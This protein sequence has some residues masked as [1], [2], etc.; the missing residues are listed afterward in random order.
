[1]VELGGG[2]A[3]AQRRCVTCLRLPTIG[4]VQPTAPFARLLSGRLPCRL[5]PEVR[6]YAD[7]DVRGGGGIAAELDH[8]L[9]IN[10]PRALGPEA[11]RR[12]LRVWRLNRR[13][14]G[15]FLGAIDTTVVRGLTG[16]PC[17][18]SQAR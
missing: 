14:A 9:A 1:M 12:A 16:L 10:V 13:W 18:R 2:G 5:R 4:T 8:R 3:F 6:Q 15:A 7:G 17:S 11:L